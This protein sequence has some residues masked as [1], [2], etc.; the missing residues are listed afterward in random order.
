MAGLSPG[1]RYGEP[2]SKETGVVNPSLLR[3]AFTRALWLRALRLSRFWG[4]D[5]DNPVFRSLGGGSGLHPRCRDLENFQ[6]EHFSE[7]PTWTLHCQVDQSSG[8]KVWSEG[9]QEQLDSVGRRR[10]GKRAC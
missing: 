2:P 5:V 6:L 10:A 3:Q 1:V 4:V 9:I 8:R 7:S